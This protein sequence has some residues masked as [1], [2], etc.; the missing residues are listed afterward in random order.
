MHFLQA[1]QK[2]ERREGKFE[3]PGPGELGAEPALA[4]CDLH[5]PGRMVIFRCSHEPYLWME[6]IITIIQV[7]LF[8]FSTTFTHLHLGWRHKLLGCWLPWVYSDLCLPALLAV[9]C[10]N[11][12]DKNY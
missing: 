2:A 7:I 9:V 6:G 5:G 12:K 4:E 1:F 11:K 3:F 10:S 8:S